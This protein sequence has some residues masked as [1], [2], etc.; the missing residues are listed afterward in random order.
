LSKENRGPWRN[1]VRAPTDQPA[2]RSEMRE[3][4]ASLP[5]SAALPP[6]ISAARR[7]EGT[8]QAMPDLRRFI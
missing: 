7:P 6:L 3:K 8:G 2:E 5:A 1:F 4:A